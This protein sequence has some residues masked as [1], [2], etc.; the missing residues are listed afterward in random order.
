MRDIEAN[1][2]EEERIFKQYNTNC[3]V[4]IFIIV[5]VVVCIEFFTQNNA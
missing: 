5:F 4:C 3:I 2:E 1:Y